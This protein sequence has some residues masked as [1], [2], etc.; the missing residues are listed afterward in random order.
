[1][2]ETT[3]LAAVWL[4]QVISRSLRVL[5]STPIS[6]AVNRIPP[7]GTSVAPKGGMSKRATGTSTRT[8]AVPDTL[9]LVALI[10]TGP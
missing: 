10:V 5:P 8:A 6:T 7:P 9:S 4:L 1:M 3:T 2:T